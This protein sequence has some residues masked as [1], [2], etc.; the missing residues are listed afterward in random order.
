MLKY[1]LLVLSTL[2]DINQNIFTNMFLKY[3][4]IISK[5][6]FKNRKEIK[7]FKLCRNC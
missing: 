6:N 5:M 4:F 2:K 7:K 3:T 1:N